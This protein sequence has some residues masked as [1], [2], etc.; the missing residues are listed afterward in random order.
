MTYADVEKID[1]NGTYYPLVGSGS[2]KLSVHYTPEGYCVLVHYKY[3]RDTTVSLKER[4]LVVDVEIM[5]F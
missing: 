4:F 5:P 3:I 2:N 1:P